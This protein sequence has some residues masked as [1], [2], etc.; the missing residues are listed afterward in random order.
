MLRIARGTQ[1]LVVLLRDLALSMPIVRQESPVR[2]TIVR[3]MVV[4]DQLAVPCLLAFLGMLAG[5]GVLFAR[6]LLLG[7]AVLG[8]PDPVV[9]L[10][11]ILML[12]VGAG[13]ML[14]FVAHATL[15]HRLALR[16]ITR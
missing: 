13:V 6:N 16:G 3:L 7:L 9:R 12:P 14:I 5:L 15:P 10:V 8:A 1:I 4:F 11:P 2:V